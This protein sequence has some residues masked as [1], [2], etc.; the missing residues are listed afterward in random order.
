MKPSTPTRQRAPRPRKL[1][2]TRITFVVNDCG[3]GDHQA[4]FLNYARSFSTIHE[5]TVVFVFPVDMRSPVVKEFQQLGVRVLS[6]KSRTRFSPKTIFQ[7]YQIFRATQPQIIHSQHPIAGIN[8]RIAG[9]IYR[10]ERPSVKIICEQRNVAQGLSRIARLLERLTFPVADL[11][12]CSSKGV[13]RSYFGSSMVLNL[14]DFELKKRKHY[15]FFNS[16]NV[17][18]ASCDRPGRRRSRA[19]FAADWGIDQG[20][21]VFITVAKFTRQKDYPVLVE[22]FAKARE[23]LVTRSLRLICVGEGTEMASARAIARRLGVD[24]EITFAGYRADVEH[25]LCG[26]DCFVLTSLWEGLPKALLEAM[27]IPLPCVATCVA[28]TEDVIR[29]EVD[30]L[31]IPPGDVAACAQALV[32]VANDPALCHAIKNRAAQ[33]V[34]SFSASEQ[35]KTLLGIYDRLL[36]PNA[37]RYFSTK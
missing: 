26:A 19:A 34:A 27:S 16:I 14:E 31:L 9:W 18:L 1:A 32:R 12:L 36:P 30:G 6:L 11:I 28:G 24:N 29:H 2:S 4:Q 25:L 20:D 21:F 13:E 33:R 23:L 10:A 7:T 15:T 8:A 35:A 5:L 3:A 22:A 17:D 37:F